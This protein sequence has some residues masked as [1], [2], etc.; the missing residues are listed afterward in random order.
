M[1]PLR[2]SSVLPPQGVHQ[3]RTPR[4][5]ENTHSKES[6][7]RL[8]IPGVSFPASLW[9]VGLRICVHVYGLHCM[10]EVL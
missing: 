5:P 6:H 7:A 4:L 3:G 2:A 8:H 10:C 1:P 9:T